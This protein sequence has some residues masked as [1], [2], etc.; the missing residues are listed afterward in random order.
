MKLKL[1]LASAVL[2]VTLGIGLIIFS[3]QKEPGSPAASQK[4]LANASNVANSTKQSSKVVTGK[5]S[6]VA[7]NTKPAPKWNSAS[8]DPK[9]AGL[10]NWYQRYA[11]S[12][13]AEKQ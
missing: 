11:S 6:N 10:V 5:I 1:K 7:P 8:K 12:S 3:K 9:L 13:P 2:V 4:P